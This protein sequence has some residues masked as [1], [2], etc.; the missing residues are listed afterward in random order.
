MITCISMYVSV[1]TVQDR[2]LTVI[3]NMDY[4]NKFPFLISLGKFVHI[5]FITDLPNCNEYT[6]VMTV[7]DRFSKYALFVPLAS[8]TAY[9]VAKQ[10]FEKVVS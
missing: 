5:D 8:S 4:S 3:R 10:F 6:S 1:S 2:N 7:V 9:D